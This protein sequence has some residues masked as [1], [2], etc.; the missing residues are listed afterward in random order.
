MS[1]SRGKISFA[2]VCAAFT[3]FGVAPAH[4][5]FNGTTVA[6]V[7]ERLSIANTVD[8]Q[9]GAIIAGTATG[10]VTVAPT[11]ARTTTGGATAAGGT[12]TAAEWVGFGRRNQQVRI[13]F[14]APTIQITRVSGTQ[15]MT[16]RNFVIQA[17]VANGLTQIGAGNGPPRYRISSTNG[18]FLFT[19]GAQLVVGANQTPGNYKGDYTLT[20][21]YQ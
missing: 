13:S 9:F 18:L 4:A 19:V 3:L 5:Q 7:V 17:L 8:L 10:N 6:F 21:D 16:V 2:A 1:V 14:G 20:V 15:T 11:G 12:V